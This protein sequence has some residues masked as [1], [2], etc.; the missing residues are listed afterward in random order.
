LQQLEAADYEYRRNGTCNLFT[1]T[2][3]LTGWRHIDVTDGE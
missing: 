1:T 3:P 2:E